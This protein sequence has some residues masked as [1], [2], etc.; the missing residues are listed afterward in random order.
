MIDGDVFRS[1]RYVSHF[2]PDQEYNPFHGIYA[3]KRDD[4][5]TSVRAQVPAG[6]SVLDLGGGMGRMSVPLARDYH[7]TLC[8]ISTRMLEL[9]EQ[10]AR[11]TDSPNLTTM[12]LDAGST[13]P[14]ADDTFDALLSI[15]L[16]VH[17]ADPVAALNEM[18][19]VLKPDGAAW[20]D[21]S[22]NSPWW[23][24][25]YP[26]YVGRRPSRWVTTWR[27][28]GVLP[29]W[30]SIV[31]HYSPSEFHAMLRAGRFSVGSWHRYGPPWCA[32]W[33]LAVCR[34]GAL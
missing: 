34:P 14:F 22:S 9:A 33:V 15:D 19:R 3:E 18:R 32:K 8:D 2:K 17:L 6:A 27:G 21:I 24:L 28:G 29:E 1:N 12:Q 26:R 23:L 25:R 10:R 5:L 31:R 7:V 30:Q 11:E 20:I 4:I 13:L 16:L